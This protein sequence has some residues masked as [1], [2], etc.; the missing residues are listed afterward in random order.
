MNH[1][2]FETTLTPQKALEAEEG[3]LPRCS[4]GCMG[5]APWPPGASSQPIGPAMS[6]AYSPASSGCSPLSS[7]PRSSNCRAQHAARSP[8]RPR[9]CGRRRATEGQRQHECAPHLTG[10]NRRPYNMMVLSKQMSVRVRSTITMSVSKISRPSCSRQKTA[11]RCSS[12]QEETG[13]KKNKGNLE[14]LTKG[15]NRST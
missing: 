1:S 6:S 13:K 7:P 9:C 4:Q 11:H 10:I 15:F 12:T 14:K 2:M 5:R 3:P 8:A